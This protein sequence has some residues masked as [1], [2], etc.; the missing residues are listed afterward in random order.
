MDGAV[1]ERKLRAG[2]VSARIIADSSIPGSKLVDGSVPG[3]KIA[4]NAV[5]G[6]K[7]APAAVDG[8][9]LA[10]GAV[11]E[12]KIESGAVSARTIADNSI[13]GT[14]L[15]DGLNIGGKMINN[16]IHG[17][18]IVDSSIPGSK[19]A[20]GTITSGLLAYLDSISGGTASFG[21]AVNA[22]SLNANGLSL[23]GDLIARS[24]RLH[25][26]AE[27]HI[28]LNPFAR[29]AGDNT[30]WIGGGGGNGNLNVT[31]A[32]TVNGR[33]TA[34]GGIQ[35]GSTFLDGNSMELRWNG[36]TPFVDFSNDPNVDF[37]GRM[38]LV[39]DANLWFQGV[40]LHVRATD[41]SS[42]ADVH[43]RRFVTHAADVAELFDVNG[44]PQPGFVVSVD[45]DGEGKLRVSEEEYD[46]TVAGVVS[47]AGEILSGVVLGQEGTMA[48]GDTPVA[49]TGR[50]Y[51]WCDA[52][53]GEI[54]PGDRLVAS[55]T[56]GHAMKGSDKTRSIG[57]AVG[58][59]LTGLK[60]GRGL[61]LVLI[62]VR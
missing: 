57:S 33:L 13:P 51:T 46:E 2:S 11:S 62:S 28:Y 22:G 20:N 9:R 25:I 17:S 55:A 50:V 7:L 45:P 30:V 29:G 34:N 8:S 23:G 14:K 60:E 5:S 6:N 41:P 43:A 16:S 12:S 35:V 56:P 40:H 10:D 4:D 36:G 3:G 59:A 61:V 54:K 24:G 44:E 27:E 53:F 39:D 18:K 38:I 37:D 26:Q 32:A 19:I 52:S 58:K 21:G 47:G 31:G 48:F 1:T 15:A 42:F 49:V